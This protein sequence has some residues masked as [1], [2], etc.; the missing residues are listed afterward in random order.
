[1]R[2]LVQHV[3]GHDQS[4]EVDYGMHLTRSG[5]FIS[6]DKPLAHDETLHV[7]FAPKKDA[8]LVS[9]FARVTEVS[10]QGVRAKFVSLD[11][12]SVQLIESC[13]G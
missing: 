13:L 7:Q 12:E 2:F 1:M 11:A 4:H 5:L 8:R 6:T 9:A 3:S 10:P